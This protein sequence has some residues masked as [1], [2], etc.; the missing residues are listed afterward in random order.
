[1]TDEINI[2]DELERKT[3]EALSAVISDYEQGICSRSAAAYALRAIFNATAGLC[4]NEAFDLL[5]RASAEIGEEREVKSRFFYHPERQELVLLTY[6]YGESHVCLK[7]ASTKQD[8]EGFVW[9]RVASSSFD[10]QLDPFAA[11]RQRFGAYADSL[12]RNGYLEIE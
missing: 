2:A 10:D 6:Q 9:S 3:L 5:N 12:E 1:M 7:R 11:A 4:G 8:Q